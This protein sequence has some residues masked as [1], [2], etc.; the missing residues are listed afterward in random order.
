MTAADEDDKAAARATFDST[1]LVQTVQAGGWHRRRDEASGSLDADHSIG[2][3]STSA[4]R[5]R[6]EH[7]KRDWSNTNRGSHVDFDPGEDLPLENGKQAVS[8][9]IRH[10]SKGDRS[11]P[12]QRRYGGTSGKLLSKA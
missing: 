12:W 2:Y 5:D 7:L 11:L 10:S 1:T 8:S 4:G 3:Y 6:L 9:S